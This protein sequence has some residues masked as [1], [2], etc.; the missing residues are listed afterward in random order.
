MSDDLT[1]YASPLDSTESNG[2]RGLAVWSTWLRATFR[3]LPLLLPLA[4]LPAAAITALYSTLLPA[5]IAPDEMSNTVFLQEVCKVV[6]DLLFSPILLLGAL[7]VTRPSGAVPE[8]T[9]R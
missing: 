1:P 7:R 5:T 2:A 8:I 9:I 6:V 3:G 4:L